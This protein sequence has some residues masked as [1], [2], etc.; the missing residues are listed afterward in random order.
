MSAGS[1]LCVALLAAG[2]VSV[3]GARIANTQSRAPESRPD[4]DIR[5]SRAAA[6]PRV[7]PDTSDPPTADRRGLRLNRDSGTV[8]VLAAPGLSIRQGAGAAQLRGLLASS[9]HQLGL[10]AADLASLVLARDY[11]SRSNGVRHVEFKQVVD[12][13]PVFDST[14]AV[15]LRP[16]GSV[17]RLTS[18]AVALDGRDSTTSLSSSDARTVARSHSVDGSAGPASLVW[19]PLDGRLR[20]AWHVTV[21]ALDQS[22]IYDVLVDA[23]SAALLVRRNRVRQADGTGR[24]LQSSPADL[25]LPDQMPAGSGGASC[26]PAANHVLRSLNAPFRDPATVLAGTGRLEGNNTRIFRGSG[27]AAATGTFGGGSWQFDFPFNSAGAAE[28]FLF[29]AMNFAHDFFYDLGFDEAAGNFQVD[30]FGRGG[31]GGDPLR[32]NARASGRNNA[33]YVHAPDGSSPTINMF[34]WDG[35]GCWAEDVDGDGTADLD[36]DFDTD[37]ILHE[38]HHGVSLRLN[39]AFTGSEAGAMG[40]GGGDFFAYSI[41]GDTSLAEYSRAGGLRTVN[42]KHY[43]DWT[44]LLGLFCEVHDNGEIWANVLWDVRERLRTDLV[45]GSDAAAINEAHQLYVDALALS[46]PSPTMLDMRDAM[47]DADAL[48]NAGTPASQNYCRL[49][50]SFASRG[51]GLSATDTADNGLNRVGPAY[52][53]P[54]GCTAP[55][56]PPLVSVVASTPTATEAGLIPGAFTFSRSGS[57]AG[58]IAVRYTIG[59]TATPAIDFAQLQGTAVIPAGAASVVVAVTPINDAFVENNETVVVAITA[60]GGYAIGSPLS[61]T[62]TILSDDVAPDMVVSEFTAPRAGGAGGS[63]TVTDTTRNQGVGAAAATQ[64]SFHLSVNAVLDAGDTPLGNRAVPALAA[65]AS[66]AGPTVLTLPSP[67]SAGTYYL[68]AKS[69]ATGVVTESSEANNTRLAIIAIGP[70][71]TVPTMSAPATGGAGTSIV[72]SDTTS[73]TGAGSAPAS[74]TRFFLSN[75]VFLDA[76]DAPLETRSV[77]ALA[78]GASSSGATAVTIPGGTPPGTYYLFAQA[79][80]GGVVAEA[81]ETNN[82]RFVL[83][84][85][86]PDLTVSAL[87]APARAAAGGTITVTDTTRNAGSGSSPA[88]STAFYLSTNFVLD[89]ADM[90]LTGVRA[91]PALAAS[92]SSTGTTSV[93]LP[94]VT[95]GSWILIAVADD[96]NG[97]VETQETNNT[98]FATIQIGPDLTFLTVTAPSTAT[99]GGSINVSAVVRNAGAGTAG[100]SVVR[101]YVSNDLTLDASDLPLSAVRDVSALAMDATHSG[102]TA[103]PLPPGRTGPQYLLVVADADKTVVETSELNNVVGRFVQIAQ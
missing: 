24:V 93:I 80:A 58:E 70:D 31:L 29:F 91:V 65:G 7:S 45:R 97:V 96:G 19:L 79:D 61:A 33:N 54:A 103:V 32:A 57:T 4:F 92:A 5:D 28:T 86:G 102:T 67:M 2:L 44:C 74:V 69:D 9:A 39:T 20:L 25:R 48:R 50:E 68:F 41:N 95:A 40:E 22:D 83:L 77:P 59:G 43:G 85:I 71:L 62:V 66:S 13:Y 10:D 52:D 12:G 17:A 1:R 78:P 16:D 81:G 21:S 51:M 60:G 49:W 11:T 14:V 8:R 35:F 46:P 3:P 47:L 101:F 36:G 55:P 23:D 84:R 75:N 88:S 18:N 87:S 100:P 94:G 27:G 26:P 53:V 38:Y 72:V 15:H 34:L 37:I 82:T 42:S 6:P 30:N 98:R 90:R 63:I 76:A 99:A 89:A 73:N 56:A 64:T